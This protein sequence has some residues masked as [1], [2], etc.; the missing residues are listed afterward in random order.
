MFDDLEIDE[1]GIG[2]ILL[3]D[4]RISNAARP[5]TSIQRLGTANK[6]ANQLIRPTTSSGNYNLTKGDHFPELF[7]QEQEELALRHKNYKQLLKDRE[8]GLQDQLLLVGD[9]YAWPQ[10]LFR[11]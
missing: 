3:D 7:G 1:E 6:G 8:W 9:I 2:D 5:G 10:H 11:I 4:H